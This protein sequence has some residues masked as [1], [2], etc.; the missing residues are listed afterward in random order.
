[1]K[2]ETSLYAKYSKIEGIGLFTNK[3]LKEGE[4]IKCK[5]PEIS[6]ENYKLLKKSLSKKDRELFLITDDKVYDVRDNLLRYF[7]HSNNPN[8]DWGNGLIIIALRNIKTNEELTINYGWNK[9]DLKKME[10][11]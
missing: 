11:K 10:A 2:K 5:S 8:M 3:S 4:R 9:F 7:N 1:M 6:K